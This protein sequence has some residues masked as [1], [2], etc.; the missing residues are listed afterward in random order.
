[1]RPVIVATL[2]AGLPWPALAAGEFSPRVAITPLVGYRISGELEGEA[3]GDTGGQDVALKDASLYGLV[4]NIP[5]QAMRSGDYTE[6]ELYVSRQTVGVNRVPEG[7]DPDLD[8]EITHLLVG[9]TYVG[10]GERV[11]PFLGAGI[12]AAHLSPDADGYESDTVFAF[13]IGVGLHLFPQQRIGGRIETRVLG[14]VTDSD[15]ALLCASGPAGGGC[16]FR[17][18]GNVL[19]Q[20]EL[21]A[22]LAVRF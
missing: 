11:R 12:G 18:T 13:G 14:A 4:I 7:V 2:L 10:P 8:L 21:T 16:A 5:A 17:G 22:G 1:M 19:W 9:G 15:S 3:A 20:W 6:W